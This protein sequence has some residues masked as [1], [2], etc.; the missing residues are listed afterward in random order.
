MQTWSKRLFFL[1]PFLVTCGVT[2]QPVRIT[3]A[4][5]EDRN[6]TIRGGGKIE[7]T[8]TATPNIFQVT[9]SESIVIHNHV[10]DNTTTITPPADPI[11]FINQNDVAYISR[12][13]YPD[14]HQTL[15]EIMVVAAGEL[16]DR[17]MDR[18]A[19][20]LFHRTEDDTLWIPWEQREILEGDHWQWGASLSWYE[21][22]ASHAKPPIHNSSNEDTLTVPATQASPAVVLIDGKL[23]ANTTPETVNIGTPNRGGLDSESTRTGATIYYLYGIPPTSGRG[24]DLILS[25]N[26]PS[27]GPA[28]FSSWT[29]IGAWIT[30][31]SGNLHSGYS[32]NGLQRI[33]HKFLSTDPI[34]TD[35]FVP[36]TVLKPETAKVA[37]IRVRTITEGLPTSEDKEFLISLNG[38]DT[39]TRT[40]VIN[41]NTAI[42]NTVDF[43]IPIIDTENRLWFKWGTIFEP[44]DNW[45]A[46]VYVAGWIE[47]PMA[48]K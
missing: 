7:W 26:S 12:E 3:E 38:T 19:M 21:R 44:T 36:L 45:E 20:I 40:G 23:F 16:P 27:S 47:N 42:D 31:N 4:I 14:T 24:F 29:Y 11:E 5:P 8:E 48:Y 22:L 15:D 17:D 9:F 46:Y 6:L 30:G 41:Q 25:E 39:Y 32:T 37:T 2:E 33:S 43:E 1:L 18:G 35:S 13:I 34:V 28:D 10:T